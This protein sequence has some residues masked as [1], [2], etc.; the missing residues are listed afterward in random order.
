MSAAAALAASARPRPARRRRPRA[1]ARRPP[2]PDCRCARPRRTA[3]LPPPE[4]LPLPPAC[5]RRRRLAC[6]WRR[7]GRRCLPAELDSCPAA[8]KGDCDTAG[9]ALAEV[10]RMKA[11][12][13]PASTATPSTPIP[14]IAAIPC[15][16]PSS[17]GRLPLL[18]RG[19]P[20]APVPGSPVMSGPP[21]ALATLTRPVN[22]GLVELDCCVRDDPAQPGSAPD[23]VLDEPPGHRG[24]APRSPRRRRPPGRGSPGRRRRPPP[25]SA[26]SRGSATGRCRRT[27]RRSSAAACSPVPARAAEP[28]VTTAATVAAVATDST[29]R[30]PRNMKSEYW[31]VR[32]TS[33]PITASPASPAASS[34][35]RQAAGTVR[36]AGTARS[37]PARRTGG[38]RVGQTNRQRRADQQAEGPG[39]R[40]LVHPRRVIARLVEVGHQHRGAG[41]EGER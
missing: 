27:G 6:R 20:P 29:T 9:C 28:G 24:H 36:S 22:L 25:W 5:P 2:C 3:C 19:A 1:R 33:S 35:H 7:R 21:V 39:V 17:P 18:G 23:G 12:T 4:C 32:N 41:G 26:R 34:S 16:E 38:L 14:P 37:A 13:T 11:V 10:S 40:S 8:A 15:G 31:L 30:P